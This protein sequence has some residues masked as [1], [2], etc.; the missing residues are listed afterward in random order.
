MVDVESKIT[1]VDSWR[2]ELSNIMICEDQA[3]ILHK[4]LKE[5]LVVKDFTVSDVSGPIFKNDLFNLRRRF[6]NLKKSIFKNDL[7]N[8]PVLYFGWWIPKFSN[9]KTAAKRYVHA[10]PT[11][12]ADPAKRYVHV[13]VH[14]YLTFS[15]TNDTGR[16]SVS[17]LQLNVTYTCTWNLWRA[18]HISDEGNIN[19]SVCLGLATNS[20]TWN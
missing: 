11:R 7:K 16:R 2:L 14:V 1:V 6:S 10:S 4:S 12:V 9:S 19:S 18:A 17:L 13:Y 8:D 20:K 15:W 5:L 3:R